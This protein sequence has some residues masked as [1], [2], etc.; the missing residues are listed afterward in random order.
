[1]K[2]FNNIE[3]L[4]QK[5]AELQ[6]EI[7]SPEVWERI[8]VSLNSR[9]AKKRAVWFRLA[10]VA[11]S[12]ALIVS[13][14]T[15]LW[16]S[17]FSKQISTLDE[18]LVKKISNHEKIQQP[19]S[20]KEL[21]APQNIY[22]SKIIES[23]NNQLALAPLAHHHKQI[24]EN[25]SK[26]QLNKDE[27]ASGLFASNK[28]E[29]KKLK[30]EYP[31]L[32]LENRYS[33]DAIF[34]MEKP[35]E[36]K[37]NRTRI[38]IGGSLTPVYSYGTKS[39]GAEALQMDMNSI[40]ANPT[41]K[42]IIHA[43]GGLNINVRAG[44]KWAVES[45]VRY[46]RMGHRFNPSIPT[47]P[48]NLENPADDEFMKKFSLNNSMGAIVLNNT[49]E[50]KVEEV[51]EPSR[52]KGNILPPSYSNLLFEDAGVTSNVEQ[53]VDYLEVPLTIRY[54]L[55]DSKLSLSLSAGASANFMVAN[56]VY[57]KSDNEQKNIGKTDN[58][59]SIAL[60]THAGLSLSV[61]IVNRL[62]LQ[63]EPRINY[64]INGFGA[65]SHV[66]FRPYSFGIYSGIQ[67]KFGK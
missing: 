11:A 50:H 2:Y 8:E 51:P 16:L 7:P 52:G 36:S 29:I 47:V 37:K 6:E 55:L 61:P 14:S 10:G 19:T 12:L 18:T 46:A 49:P 58:I 17:D 41:E 60:S 21:F 65:N 4:Y 25:V 39:G 32:I 59:A 22:H 48:I 23:K 1:M 34:G 3:E 28:I 64:F 56:N 40:E 35:D 63:I 38:E 66:R 27:F 24:S 57:L 43:G 5:H 44:N 20:D 45:G 62:S 13:L 67:Y 42:G 9:Q 33:A 31:D 15:W 30:R 54:Y 53:A 26:I